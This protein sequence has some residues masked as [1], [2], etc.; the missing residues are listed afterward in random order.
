MQKVRK[1]LYININTMANT[2]F[3]YQLEPYKGSQTRHTCPQCMR[4]S[5]FTRYIDFNGHYLGHHVGKCNRIDKCGY[6]YTPADYFKENPDGHTGRQAELWKTVYTPPPPEKITFLDSAKVEASRKHL[7]F[8]NFWRY[9]ATLF[10]NEKANELANLYRLGT[11]RKWRNDNGFSVVFWQIDE[12]GNV[13]QGKVMAYNPTT[14]RRLK[15]DDMAERMADN[16]KYRTDTTGEAKISFIG[17]QLAGK[18]ANLKQCFF[19]AHLIPMF[20]DS[21]VCIVESEKTAIILA[22]IKPECIWIA[23]GG[24]N[25]ASWG[26]SDVYS[27]LENRNVILYPDLGAFE[28]WSERAKILASVANS[29]AVSD[30]LEQMATDNDRSAGLDLADFFTRAIAHTVTPQNAHTAHNHPHQPPHRPHP[31]TPNIKEPPTASIPT[32]TPEPPTNPEPQR[33]GL[34][35]GVNIVPLAGCNVIEIDSLPLLWLND[36]EL[37]KALERMKGHEH[38]IITAAYPKAAELIERFGLEIETIN[39]FN[40]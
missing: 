22:G 26:K 15:A 12:A 17:K 40:H 34:P 29:V 35:Q 27:C 6:H 4:R 25:G 10:G 32:K 24:K 13:R 36:T 37:I 20:P 7:H 33:K 5:E 2:H 14:G 21:P 16:G 28:N 19:G 30:L 8:N 3:Q 39:I 38:A 18:D 23:T 1:M 9:L 31:P 11:S